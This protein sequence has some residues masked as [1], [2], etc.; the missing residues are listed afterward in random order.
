MIGDKLFVT[1]TYSGGCQN[2]SFEAIGSS[3][4]MK[5]LPPKRVMKIIHNGNGDV[6]RKLE[7]KTLEINVSEL[8]AN[9]ESGSET[10]LLLAGFDGELKYVKQ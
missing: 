4:I 6:C 9:Q 10:I 2:H 7:T 8:S 3:I 5:S 1:I